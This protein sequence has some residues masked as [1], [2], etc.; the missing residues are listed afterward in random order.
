MVVERK[1]GHSEYVRDKFISQKDTKNFHR[2]INAIMKGSEQEQWD[3]RNL[4]PGKSDQHIAEELASYFNAISSEYCP[5]SRDRE[6][7]HPARRLA[8]PIR[9]PGRQSP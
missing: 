5:L 2:S 4:Y 7:S 3:I 9:D 1:K 8:E 6:S